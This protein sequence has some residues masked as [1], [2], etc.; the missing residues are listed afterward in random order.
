MKTSISRQDWFYLLAISL[1]LLLFKFWLTRVTGLEMHFDEAQYWTWSQQLDWSYVTKGPLLA[2][3]IAASESLFG[4]GDWQV[5]LPGWIAA[6]L[7]LLLAMVITF[8]VALAGASD[9]S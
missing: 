7:F 3:L 6:S 5:R 4:H 2:W 9:L 1:G 8:V